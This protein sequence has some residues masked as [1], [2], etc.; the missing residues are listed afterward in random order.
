MRFLTDTFCCSCEALAV[1]GRAAGASTRSAM[2]VPSL[3]WLNDHVPLKVVDLNATVFSRTC[4]RGNCLVTNRPYD[5]NPTFERVHDVSVVVQVG[6]VAIAARNSN[7][8]ASA[9]LI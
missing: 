4:V 3:S 9:F 6:V 1:W 2:F 8:H 5:I 7:R